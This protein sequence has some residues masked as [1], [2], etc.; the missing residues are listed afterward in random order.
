MLENEI[1]NQKCDIKGLEESIQF[2]S[3][4]ISNLQIVISEKQTFEN[5]ELQNEISNLRSLHEQEIT[6]L[7]SQ[8]YEKSNG[9]R[10]EKEHLKILLIKYFEV[11]EN[12]P[13]DIVTGSRSKFERKYRELLENI[14][15]MEKKDNNQSSSNNNDDQT[16][17][18]SLINN[19]ERKEDESDENNYSSNHS[20]S[21]TTSTISNIFSFISP[22]S[23]D[24]SSS[25]DSENENLERD[26]PSNFEN[27]I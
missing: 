27:D 22:F 26:K 9:W 24:G 15:D 3:K 21:S 23:Q 2:H 6:N 13:I 11:V 8:F 20:S 16:S 4:Q 10:M 19:E 7:S 5:M 1:S 12:S 17:S 14:L 18:S 25:S